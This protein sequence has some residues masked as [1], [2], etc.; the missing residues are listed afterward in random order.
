MKQTLIITGLIIAAFL[1]GYQTGNRYGIKP[2]VVTFD[3]PGIGEYLFEA[4]P[5]PRVLGIPEHIPDF[6]PLQS[7]HEY[8]TNCPPECATNRITTE[9]TAIEVLEIL[10]SKGYCQEKQPPWH[11]ATKADLERWRMQDSGAIET[12]EPRVTIKL[13]KDQ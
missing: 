11:E 7:A 12:D 8:I 1:T 6:A 10:Q 13:G 2:L 4:H 5:D 3:A 9:S